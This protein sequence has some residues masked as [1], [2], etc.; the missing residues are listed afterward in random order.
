[1]HERQNSTHIRVA[2]K[3][4]NVVDFG[5][6][7]ADCHAQLLARDVEPLGPFVDV[8]RIDD[9]IRVGAGIKLGG[10]VGSANAVDRLFRIQPVVEFV[11]AFESTPLG[12]KPAP[13]EPEKSI[14]SQIPAGQ[15]GDA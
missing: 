12:W 3:A 14:L 5:S 15:I 11:I 2:E 4:G 10:R 13:V 7:L 1:M 9:F 8:F 6:H